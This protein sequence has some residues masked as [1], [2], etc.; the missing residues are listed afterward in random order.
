LNRFVLGVVVL[1]ACGDEA[2]KG[3][4]TAQDI[5]DRFYA[6][7]N[8]CATT[9]STPTGEE[10]CVPSLETCSEADLASYDA[11]VSCYEDDCTDFTCT[12]LLSDVED[13]CGG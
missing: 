13:G 5:C 1:I 9:S 4:G 10:D 2:G 12:D 3:A 11:F 8:E 6:A 7:A